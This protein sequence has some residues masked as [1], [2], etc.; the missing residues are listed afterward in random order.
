MNY[1]KQLGI[2]FG[3]AVCYSG[4]REGQSPIDGTFPSYESGSRR[5]KIL[6]EQWKYLRIYD[7]S[8]HADLVL[9]AV[10]NE[11]LDF[12]VMLGF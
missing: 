12:K 11:K 10:R 4:Y 1:L 6:E 9:E 5:P 7:S 2:E 3:N 8:Q